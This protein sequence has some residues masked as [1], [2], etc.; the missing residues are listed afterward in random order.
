MKELRRQGTDLKMRILSGI[1]GFIPNVVEDSIVMETVYVRSF[2]F[3][4]WV[5]PIKKL[6]VFR[7]YYGKMDRLINTWTV[8][9]YC[10]SE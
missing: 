1:Y 3:L 10:V 7:K 2:L 4:Q 6:W 5:I 8:T 9:K